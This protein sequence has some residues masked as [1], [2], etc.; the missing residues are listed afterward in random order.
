VCKL[1]AV[2]G[3]WT[4]ALALQL[5]MPCAATASFSL[6]DADQFALLG[7]AGTQ[8]VGN[9][10]D[11][12]GNIGVGTG[13]KLTL[14]GGPFNL[15]GSIYFA[16]PIVPGTNYVT[17]GTNNISG[18]V[19]Q[20]TALV[21]SAL[22]ALTTLYST[23]LSVYVNPLTSFPNGNVTVTLNGNTNYNFIDVI[24]GSNTIIN[25][26]GAATDYIIVNVKG[27]LKFNN[28]HNL[29]ISGGIPADHILWNMI[30][31]VDGGDT[32]KSLTIGGAKT[33]YYGVFLALDRK[34]SLSDMCQNGVDLI[35]CDG[36]GRVFG[37][38]ATSDGFRFVSGANFS[39][40]PNTGVPEPSTLLLMGTG[41]AGLGLWRLRQRGRQERSSRDAISAAKL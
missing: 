6:G 19:T 36:L 13:G 38:T 4:I 33:E 41:L 3:V 14:S 28:I 2:A 40:P 26:V 8:M 30:E 18:S 31:G 32:S 10:S 34:I 16:D 23:A 9:N 22:S 12:V 21:T 1:L 39:A 11:I 27:E 5:G 24:P 7:D 37:G 20:N 15:T 35:G 29:N 17:S 25:I